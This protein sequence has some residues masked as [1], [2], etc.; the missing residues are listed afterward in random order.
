MSDSPKAAP[1]NTAAANPTSSDSSSSA[2]ENLA[3][4]VIGLKSIMATHQD[5]G[6][7]FM[8]SVALRVGWILG[9]H[10]APDGSQ[11][12]HDPQRAMV[13]F[14]DVSL[15]KLAELVNVKYSLLSSWLNVWKTFSPQRLDQMAACRRLAPSK[16]SA[17]KGEE[18]E[19]PLFSQRVLIQLSAR[20]IDPAARDALVTKLIEQ[21]SVLGSKFNAA[22]TRLIGRK[23]W[24]EGKAKK[25][26]D[27]VQAM[28]RFS[29]RIEATEKG[30]A[31]VED[32]VKAFKSLPSETDAKRLNEVKAAIREGRAQAR[33]IVQKLMTT[34]KLF[35]SVLGKV[36]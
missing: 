31:L 27:P 15:D 24:G 23:G 2:E 32:A 34:L 6:I 1:A 36:K 11:L 8:R 10:W 12:L 28:S 21:G 14:G 3:R 22:M 26:G 29:K 4:E 7:E 5:R 16:S 9:Y 35:D 25:V 30:L 20:R 18:V 19:Y 33:A 13:E 17:A